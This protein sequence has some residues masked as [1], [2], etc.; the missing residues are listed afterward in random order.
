MWSISCGMS[1]CVP[2]PV[3][4]VAQVSENSTPATFGAVR[5]ALLLCLSLGCKLLE[6]VTDSASYYEN[7]PEGIKQILHSHPN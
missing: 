3:T 2:T 4:T 6:N 5:E 7:T 1:I